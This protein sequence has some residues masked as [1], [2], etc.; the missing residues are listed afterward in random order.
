MNVPERFELFVLSE[1][2]KKVTSI[3]ETKVL[4]CTT[5]KI[6]REDHT[7]G[8]LLCRQLQT[9]SGPTVTYAGYRMPH[10]LEPAFELRVQTDGTINPRAALQQAIT[11]LQAQ[12]STLDDRVRVE[13]RRCRTTKK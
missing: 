8:N 10:P 6:Q 1:G 2:V 11:G 13:I 3:P 7:L 5:F 12:L 9:M 4:N